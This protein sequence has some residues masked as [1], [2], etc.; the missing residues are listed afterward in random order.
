MNR[1]QNIVLAIWA[2]LL[3]LFVAFNWQMAWRPVEVVFLFT[4]FNIPVL[5][6]LV[7]GGVAV[8]AVLRVLAELDFRTRRRRT[9]KELHD[10]K[11][12]A[13]DGLTG[14]FDKMVAKLQDQLGE[15]IET[16]L[17][18]HP[19]GKSDD[20]GASPPA[21]PA[22]ASNDDDHDADDDDDAPP[23]LSAQT[24]AT[25]AELKEAPE[26]D[27]A[28]DDAQTAEEKPKRRRRKSK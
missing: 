8:A 21:W 17:G 7:L 10:I 2:V 1:L 26:P 11:A 18:D 20:P 22:A 14:E 19:S 9:D 28:E 27:E 12:K 25:L 13:F 23:R 16:L 5:L 24:A 4:Q 15:R 3:L 6:W